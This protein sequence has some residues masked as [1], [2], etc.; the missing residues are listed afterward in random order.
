MRGI[1]ERVTLAFER[2]TDGARI[3]G[4]EMPDELI[5]MLGFDTVGGER[6]PWEILDVEGDNDLRTAA[7][8]GGE[9]MGVIR[10]GKDKTLCDSVVTA[11]KTVRNRLVH[12]FAGASQLGCR[13]I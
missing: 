10:I 12:Q 7:N 1:L 5:R 2:A 9:N 13:E 3:Q 11:N 8:G 4:N 6:L